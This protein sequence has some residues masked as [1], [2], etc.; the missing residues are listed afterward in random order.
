MPKTRSRFSLPASGRR[1]WLERRIP[2]IFAAAETAPV[3]GDDLCPLDVR[4]DNLCLLDDRAVLVDW[5]WLS[6]AN[7]DL[8]LA[9]RLPSLAVEGGPHPWQVLPG[10]PEFAALL[11]GVFAAVVGLPPPETAPTVRS[12]QRAQLDVALEWFDREL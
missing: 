9:A 10:S 5:N 12:F 4:S 8:E 1:D 7:A 6:L 3:D 2:E 11:A